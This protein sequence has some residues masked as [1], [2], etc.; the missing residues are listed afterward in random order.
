MS[1]IRPRGRDGVAPPGWPSAVRPP[2]T[3]DWQESAVNWLREV[4][5]PEYR[6]HEILRRHPELLARMAVQHV[7]AVLHAARWGYGEARADL[8][9][10]GDE[11][12]GALLAAYQDVGGRAA[13]LDREVRL[14]EQ[15]LRGERWNPRL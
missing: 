6:R 9:D 11:Q 12:L 14:V 3:E 13:A 1:D 4:L 10:V 15:A 5:P 2:G 7:G 8:P